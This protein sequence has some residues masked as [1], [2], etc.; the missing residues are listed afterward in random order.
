MGIIKKKIDTLKFRMNIRRA[1][2]ESSWEELQ[3][4][5]EELHKEFQRR[6]KKK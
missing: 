3:I 4:T 6:N 5:K 2:I 1:F